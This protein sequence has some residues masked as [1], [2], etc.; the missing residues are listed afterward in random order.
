[1]SHIIRAAGV[2]SDIETAVSGRPVA[3]IKTHLTYDFG[4]KHNTYHSEQP[5]MSILDAATNYAQTVK[6]QLGQIRTNGD[7]RTA[8]IDWYDHTGNIIETV[9]L[10]E[11]GSRYD[12]GF[13]ETVKY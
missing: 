7:L 9:N 1:M 3:I 8:V 4:G 6:Y 12:D 5:F 10:T 2:I 11:S 13:G